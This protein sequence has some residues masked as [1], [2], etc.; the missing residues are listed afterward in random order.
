MRTWKSLLATTLALGAGA[1]ACGDDGGGTPDAERPDGLTPDAEV[2]DMAPTAT[3]SAT[4][5]VNEVTLTSD[6]ATQLGMRGGS[7]SIS[8]DDLTM[9]GGE[10]VFGT[11][12]V[13]G[14][15][16][17]RYDADGTPSAPN[18]G[19]DAGTVTITGD[20]L[21]RTVGPCNFVAGAGYLCTSHGAAADTAVNAT[22]LP[23]SGT[24]PPGLIAYTFPDQTFP[25]SPGL[26]GSYLTVGGFT[27]AAFNSPAGQA[28]PI[29]AQQGTTTV[30]V[31]NAAGE[32]QTT[33]TITAGGFSVLNGYAP[34]PVGPGGDFLDDATTSVSIAKA[35]DPDWPAID[36]TTYVRGEGFAL[37]D[38]SV[39]PHAF[40]SSAADI[41]VGCNMTNGD[42]GADGDGTL[43]A[44]IISGK[45]TDTDV[46]T[47]PF[48]FI[49]PPATTEYAT[50]QC[51]FLL[52]DEATMPSAAVQAILDTN[53]T[54]VEMRVLRVAGTLVEDGLNEGRILVG[55]GLVGHTTLP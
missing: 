42:C 29:V 53:P 12:P 33:E 31:V 2:P 20:G 18:P 47:M 14:C 4:I 23:N 15:V 10:V 46:S 25:A 52:A 35:D 11:S 17:T 39:A 3:R 7:I 55:H 19:V 30:V 43:E 45:T 36:F 24:S 44:L 22:D 38:E 48:D 13:G 40:P 8:F 28:F 49:M 32:G 54:R 50:F 16:V 34:A 21:L 9:G 1:A 37:D 5:A 51:A 26:V 27:N 6:D 41:R